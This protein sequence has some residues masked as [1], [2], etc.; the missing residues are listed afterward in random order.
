MLPIYPF[1]EIIRKSAFPY[2]RK[3]IDAFMPLLEMCVIFGERDWAT[4]T[5][6]CP[7]RC[8]LYGSKRIFETILERKKNRSHI[9]IKLSYFD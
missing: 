4:W 5:S 7:A 3:E 6:K 8:Y 9:Y 1:T 2:L